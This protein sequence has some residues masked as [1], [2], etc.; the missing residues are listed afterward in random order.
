MAS[1]CLLLFRDQIKMIVNFFLCQIL[2]RSG[3]FQILSSTFFH[4]HFKGTVLDLSEPF[5]R[6]SVNAFKIY[7]L[8]S[9]GNI[10]FFWGKLENF[11]WV[12][13][14]GTVYYFKRA[15]DVYIED[16]I[17]KFHYIKQCKIKKAW[18]KSDPT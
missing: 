1:N 18:K 3:R 6:K 11:Q 9:K 13:F 17:Q 15:I 10:K 5:M 7:D 2:M 4:Q 12:K 14:P 8:V 16:S